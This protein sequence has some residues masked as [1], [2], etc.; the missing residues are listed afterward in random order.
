MTSAFETFIA[1]FFFFW[2]VPEAH[3]LHDDPYGP[4]E[5][6]VTIEITGFDSRESCEQY[7]SAAADDPSL[8]PFHGADIADASCRRGF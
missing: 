4:P 3:P 7:I 5:T 1:V 2:A 6:S 8:V